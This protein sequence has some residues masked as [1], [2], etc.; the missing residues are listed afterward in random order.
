LQGPR[1]LLLRWR[2]KRLRHGVRLHGRRPERRLERNVP[3]EAERLGFQR[4]CEIKCPGMISGRSGH[5][6]FLYRR[7]AECAAL[8]CNERCIASDRKPGQRGRAQ[9]R[10]DGSRG[11][12]V[13][14]PVASPGAQGEAAGWKGLLQ[15]RELYAAPR[16]CTTRPSQALRSPH[17]IPG[18][19]GEPSS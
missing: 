4:G 3:C 12:N 10:G 1:A 16:S 8:G 9:D 7:S 19:E 15:H 5:G 6:S 14:A 11:Q 18:A 17:D 2:Q 13:F